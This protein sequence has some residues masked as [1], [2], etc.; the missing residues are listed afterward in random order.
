[1]AFSSI[2]WT[3]LTWNPTTGCDKISAGCKNCYAEV[4]SR[5]LQAMGLPKYR[6]AFKLRVHESALDIPYKWKSRA[7]VFV[8]SMS[9]LFHEDVPIEFISR[10]FKVMV[11]CPHLTF[12]VLTKRATRLAELSS[13]LPWPSNIWMGV[14][15]EDVQAVTRIRELCKV[16][17]AVRFLSCEPLIGP[18]GRLSLR[19]IDWVI[20]GGESGPRSR[21]IE[22]AWVESI[23]AQCLVG[24]I[25]FFFKQWGGRNKKEAGRLFLG[26]THDEMPVPKPHRFR[27]ARAA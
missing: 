27:R 12:Q 15:V 3:Q 6:D 24:E 19:G 20:V 4:M 10:V 8:N 11:D 5:R 2:E 18:L 16:P 14:S 21:P 9:D 1:M 17:A 22:V 26:T 13:F 23:H 25:P 7:L